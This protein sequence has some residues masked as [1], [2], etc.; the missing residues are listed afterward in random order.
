MLDFGCGSGAFTTRLLGQLAWPRRQLQLTLVEP[1]EAVRRQAA[2]RLAAFTSSPIAEFAALPPDGRGRFDVIVANHCLYYV[3]DLKGQLAGLI[4]AL[5]PAGVLVTAIAARTNA[6]I[7]FWIAAFGLLGRDI[8]YY[9]SE[10]VR[11][12]LDSLGANYRQREVAYDL[13]FPD[14]KENRLHIIRFLLADHLAQMPLQPLLDLFDPYRH[15]GQIQIH[16]SS[17]HYTI[18]PSGAAT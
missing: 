5:A 6:L 13:T 14:T 3:P 15:S 12:A 1:A 4:D 11:A 17:D 2:P 16:A 9:T 18:H 10:D 8:P 7:Q